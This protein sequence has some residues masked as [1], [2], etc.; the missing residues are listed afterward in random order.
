MRF[1][2]AYLFAKPTGGSRA[3][4]ILTRK[5]WELASSSPKSSIMYRTDGL[6]G[7][8]LFEEIRFKLCVEIY[9]V[10]SVYALVVQ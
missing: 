1:F 8:E 3:A 9:G 6:V 4:P 2:I 7:V 10:N 5:I